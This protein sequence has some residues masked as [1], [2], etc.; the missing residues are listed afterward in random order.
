MNTF[1]NL[2]LNKRPTFFGCDASNTTGPTPLIVYLPNA[3]YTYLSNIS[4]FDLELNDSVR[5]GIVLNGYN[6]A[7]QGN[8]TFD[9]EWPTCVGCAILS[10]SLERTNT[11]VPSVCRQCFSRLCWNGTTDSSTPSPYVPALKINTANSKS[12]GAGTLTSSFALLVVG[13]LIA[14]WTLF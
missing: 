14:G 10:R 2:G 12:S 8:G 9:S 5:N 3:P 11:K 7:T 4:T 6:V 1:F 13:L